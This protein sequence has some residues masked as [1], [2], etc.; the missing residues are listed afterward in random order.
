[1]LRFELVRAHK[2]ELQH[3]GGVYDER[4]DGCFLTFEE[5]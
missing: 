3:L 4:V 1:M 2:F 5:R